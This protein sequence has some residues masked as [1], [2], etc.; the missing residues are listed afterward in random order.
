[1]TQPGDDFK[2]DVLDISE[3]LA[4]VDND[5]ELARELLGIFKQESLGLLDSLRVAVSEGDLA[6]V[7]ATGHTLKGMLANLSAD[8]ASSA[9]S[10]LERI[11]GSVERSELKPALAHLESEMAAL[12]PKLDAYL[13][14]AHP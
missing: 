1:M 3:L 5:S 6:G 2:E 9:A 11:G 8:R 10:R 7:K 4:R 12:L 14:E 13:D